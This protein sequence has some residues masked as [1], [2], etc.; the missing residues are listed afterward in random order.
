MMF[1]KPTNDIFEIRADGKLMLPR[2]PSVA[3]AEA[4]ARLQRLQAHHVCVEV[5]RVSYECIKVVERPP[6]RRRERYK[7]PRRRRRPPSYMAI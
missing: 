6:E 4:Y 5:V 7:Q 1:R 3:A 2:F